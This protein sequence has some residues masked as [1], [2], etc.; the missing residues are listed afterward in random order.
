MKFGL[1]FCLFISFETSSALEIPKDF[2]TT[3]IADSNSNFWIQPKTLETI[4]IS[5][6]KLVEF[7][8]T[9]TKDAYAEIKETVEAKAR[10]LS[11]ILNI[12]DWKILDSTSNAKDGSQLILFFGSY[13]DSSDELTMFAEAYWFP[14]KGQPESYLF[15][16]P[17]EPYTATE[18]A[19][20]FKVSM[21]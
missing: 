12:K 16:R 9:P 8:I 17:K 4:S 14:K 3:N 11:W 15:T 18:I 2:E 10:T 13:I 1:I 6:D 5:N 20:R 19:N 7:E 21:P